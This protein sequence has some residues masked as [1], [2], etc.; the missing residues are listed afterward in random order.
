MF[1]LHE[2]RM[3]DIESKRIENTVDNDMNKAR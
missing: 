3:I 1:V 2:F